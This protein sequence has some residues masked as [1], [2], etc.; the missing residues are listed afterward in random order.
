LY[1][2]GNEVSGSTYNGSL[3]TPKIDILT[4]NSASVTWSALSTPIFKRKTTDYHGA[5][6]LYN[7]PPTILKFLGIAKPGYYDGAALV[8]F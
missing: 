4:K 6:Y 1:T 2:K 7:V 5:P 8:N 3:I